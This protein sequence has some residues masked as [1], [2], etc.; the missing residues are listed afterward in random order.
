MQESKEQTAPALE[1]SVEMALAG[2][3]ALAPT[4]AGPAPAPPKL[5]R[6][7]IGEMRRQFMTVTHG[8][9]ILCGHKLDVKN[10]PKNNCPPCWEAYFKTGENRLVVLHDTL[11]T[12]GLPALRAQYGDKLVKQFARFLDNELYQE[13]NDGISEEGEGSPSTEAGSGGTGIGSGEI[14]STLRAVE[15]VGQETRHD[16]QPDA[17]GQAAGSVDTVDQHGTPVVG[18]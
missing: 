3:E 18:L 1:P 2:K 14:Q 7:Q 6:K 15:P 13:R 4:L 10:Q 17:T 16:E 5:T 8:T 9:V 11:V 12:K